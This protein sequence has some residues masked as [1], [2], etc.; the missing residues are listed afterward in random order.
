MLEETE[1][2]ARLGCASKMDPAG[3]ADGS[4]VSGGERGVRVQEVTD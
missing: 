3:L 2:W 1:K 4:D